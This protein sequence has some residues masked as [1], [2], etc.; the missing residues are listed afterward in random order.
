MYRRRCEEIVEEPHSLRELTLREDPTTSQSTQTKS[1]RQTTRYYKLFTKMK[2]RARRRFEQCLHVDFINQ[3]TR[4]H[5][6]C[7]LADAFHGC[8]VNQHATRI[9]KIRDHDQ[10]RLRSDKPVEIVWQYLKPVFEP[11]SEA[12]D[13][14]AEVTSEREH[15]LVCRMFKQYFVARLDQCGHCEVICE[16][17]PG[18]RHHFFRSDSIPCRNRLY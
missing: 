14:R 15:R 8:V 10:S 1:L 11:A 5:A 16:R 12:F 6:S 2:A 18:R 3:H 7:D 17:R 9:V 13:I 4:A